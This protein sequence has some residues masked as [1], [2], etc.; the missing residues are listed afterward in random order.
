[1]LARLE[2]EGLH[3]SPEADRYTLIRRVYFDL[4]GLPPTPERSR[5]LSTTTSPD[6]YEKVVDGLFASPQYGER[7]ARRVARSG[8][9]RRFEGL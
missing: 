4:I 6:A 9:L 2:K 7:W 1:M 5:R 8:A 3:P